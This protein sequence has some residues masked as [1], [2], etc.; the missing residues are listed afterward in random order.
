MTTSASS[1]GPR[2]TVDDLGYPDTGLRGHQ[3][4][5]RLVLDLLEPSDRCASRWVAVGEQPPAARQPLGVLGVAAE[6]AHL[7]RAPVRVVPDEPR[8]ADSLSRRETQV[9][10]L[11]AERGESGAHA[12]DGAARPPR[13]RTRAARMAPPQARARGPPAH[14]TERRPRARRCRRQPADEP[15]GDPANRS[16]ELGA[17]DDEHGDHEREPKLG[18]APP[19]PQVG[20]DRQPICFDQPTEE[21]RERDENAHSDDQVPNQRPATS[22]QRV[23]DYRQRKEH[24][25]KEG[26]MPERRGPAQ[27]RVERPGDARVLVRSRPRD[28][29][30][31]RRDE[32]R[33]RNERNVDRPAVP[34]AWIPSNEKTEMPGQARRGRL[35]VAGADRGRQNCTCLKAALRAVATQ[36]DGLVIG[37]PREAVSDVSSIL[38]RPWTCRFSS[39]SR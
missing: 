29:G 28:H 32:R 35:L 25:S 38:T 14:G 21:A 26:D 7:Q 37:D 2:P 18:E 30:R 22:K 3:C 19:G 27:H 9:A 8:R 13:I 5:Q 36:G 31:E 1:S 17:G 11:D 23:R 16:D 39:S 20:L 12:F 34:R 24:R 4:R 6:H 15:R 33:Q 10:R